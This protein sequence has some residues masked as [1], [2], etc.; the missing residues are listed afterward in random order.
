[1]N[2]QFQTP[3]EGEVNYKESY[4]S[5][6]KIACYSNVIYASGKQSAIVDVRC[7]KHDSVDKLVF[8]FGQ[9]FGEENVL[10]V[11]TRM[12][13]VVKIVVSDGGKRVI[14]LEDVDF[15]W[16]APEVK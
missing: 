16:N 7:R 15:V 3:L 11:D 13:E 2:R 10:E 9:G 4:E 8:D 12:T 14:H 1:M 5:L 6:G